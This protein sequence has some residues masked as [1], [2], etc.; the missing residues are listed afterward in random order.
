MSTPAPGAPLPPPPAQPAATTE[1]RKPWYKK[2]WV[3]AIGAVVGIGIIGNLIGGGKD[4]PQPL[5]AV[6]PIETSEA[7]TPEPSSTPAETPTETQTPSPTPTSEPTQDEPAAPELTLGQKNAL[8]SAEQYLSMM[9]FSR[10]GIIDQLTS[11]YGEG[12]DPADAEFAIAHL[13]ANGLVDW[14][15]Q[16]AKSAQQYLDMMGFSRE[17]LY[18]QL[19]SEYGEGFTHEQAEHA[20]TVV[21]Y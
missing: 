1:T 10:V 14:N 15:E 16:A 3:I 6:T 18:E 9:A 17:S 4:A 13:E 2:W 5:A 20:L 8:R 19:T 12:Y 7:A 11:E 21:G